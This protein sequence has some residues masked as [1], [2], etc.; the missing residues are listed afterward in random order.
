VALEGVV[1]LLLV[2]VVLV[3]CE[4]GQWLSLVKHIRLLLALGGLSLLL[5]ATQIF[6]PSHRLAAEKVAIMKVQE[7]LVAQAAV[8]VVLLAHQRVQMLVVLARVAKALLVEQ[9]RKV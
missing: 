2:V 7:L 5:V 4:Q 8:V 9:P 3:V 6:P 1:A